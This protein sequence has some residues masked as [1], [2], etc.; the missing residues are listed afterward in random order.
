MDYNKRKRIIHTNQTSL[1]RNILF[2]CLCFALNFASAQIAADFYKQA[3]I[4]YRAGEYKK[5]ALEYSQGLREDGKNAAI[6][7]YYSCACSWSLA[8]FSDSA[9]HYLHFIIASDKLTTKNVRDIEGDSDFDSLKSNQRWRLII[10]SLYKKAFIGVKTLSEDI[11]AGLRINPSVDKYDIAVA[12]ATAGN[13]DSAFLYLNSIVNT[14][15][16]SFVAYEDLLKEKSFNSLHKDPRWSLIADEVKKNAA[17]FTCTHHSAPAGGSMKFTIDHKSK[18]LKSDGKGSYLD[19]VDKVSSNQNFAYNLLVSG[20]PGLIQSGNWKEF[21]PR[22]LLLDLNSPVESSGAAS[23]GIIKDHFA[24]FHSFSKM[25]SSAKPDLI[26]NFNDIIIGTT[27]ESPRTEIHVHINGKLHIL[28]FGFWGFGQ[29]GE[30]YSRGGQINGN[31]TTAVK[32]TRH[33]ET[34][35]SIEAPKGSIGRLWNVDNRTHPIDK[36]LFKTSFVIHLENQ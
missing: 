24:E 32:I 14:D 22:Y 6:D 33:S 20:F 9:F 27:V 8:G 11:R 15:Y 36:R 2:L 18:F 28:Q 17:A 10:D 1:K 30:P 19:N 34:S 16:N 7:K 12:W 29:C 31:G 13:V 35:F 3:I 25:D 4:H 23:Q 21:S 5:S 26:Y